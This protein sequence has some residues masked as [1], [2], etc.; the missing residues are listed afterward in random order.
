MTLWH[1]HSDLMKS[2]L[3]EFEFVFTTEII[4]SGGSHLKFS[5][6]SHLKFSWKK[7]LPQDRHALVIY[8]ISFCGKVSIVEENSMG[9]NLNLTMENMQTLNLI[10]FPGG[11]ISRL[12]Q[13]HIM[14]RC[15]FSCTSKN[16][17]SR[18]R[19]HEFGGKLALVKYCGPWWW[20]K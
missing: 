3:S 12:W 10:F 8:N 9:R 16:S 2:G 14:E 1:L 13:G 7:F 17:E 18:K 20:S 11:L 6:G 5:K 4:F 19:K 15:S